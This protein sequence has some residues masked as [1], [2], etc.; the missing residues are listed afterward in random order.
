MKSTSMILAITVLVSASSA[1]AE[2][3][4]KN[5]NFFTGSKD[6][7][8]PGGFEPKIERVYNSKTS[9]KGDFG[10]GWGNG[11]SFKSCWR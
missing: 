1:F 11:S 8:Y 7:L 6:M 5:G 9:H 10:N 4:L 2:V 3:S